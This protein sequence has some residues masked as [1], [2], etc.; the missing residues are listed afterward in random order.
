MSIP[1]GPR[2]FSFLKRYPS[3]QASAQTEV[4]TLSTFFHELA[5]RHYG[6]STAQ[7]LVRLAKASI[8]S[9]VTLAACSSS[10]RLLSDQLEH[11]Q[12]NLSQLQHEVD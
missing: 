6:R 7:A 5:P 4:E 3:A 9:G 8:S 10:L 12:T 1:R 11:S 2:R